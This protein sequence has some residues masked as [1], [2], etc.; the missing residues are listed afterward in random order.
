MSGVHQVAVASCVTWMAVSVGTHA[1]ST[2]LWP[3]YR[4]LS[5]KDKLAWCNRITSACHVRY[6]SIERVLNN[7]RFH[8]PR[9]IWLCEG[10]HSGGGPAASSRRCCSTCKPAP[11]HLR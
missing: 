7:M 1:A 10:C 9:E 6:L 11:C 3:K 2:Q 8:I 4:V 5:F